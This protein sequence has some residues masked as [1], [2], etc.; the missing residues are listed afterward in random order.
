MSPPNFRK[1]IFKNDF[2]FSYDLDVLESDDGFSNV[3]LLVIVSFYG[4]NLLGC[5]V[6]QHALEQLL[7]EEQAET[8]PFLF[9]HTFKFCIMQVA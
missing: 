1:K 6:N 8:S 9:R 7:I 5:L 4:F 3:S 2:R